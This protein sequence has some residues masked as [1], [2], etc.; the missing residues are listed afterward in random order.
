MAQKTKKITKKG[1]KSYVHD[2]KGLNMNISGKA[3][4]LL[5][6]IEEEKAKKITDQAAKIATSVKRKTI[7]EPHVEIVLSLLDY[8]DHQDDKAEKTKKI[9]K[10]GLR[11][12]VHQKEGLDMNIAGN[13]IEKL[14][15]I[16]EV[17]AKKLALE[18]GKLAKSIKRKTIKEPQVVIV[19]EV[20]DYL[21]HH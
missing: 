9:T 2:D 14:S 5:V 12:L 1:L 15:G 7:Q 18:A 4:D 17:R 21:E 20:L 16:E 13:A 8:A 3:L 11:D 19:M 6:G 10:K